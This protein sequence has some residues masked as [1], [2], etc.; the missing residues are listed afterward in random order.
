MTASADLAASTEFS[1]SRRHSTV[2]DGYSERDVLFSSGIMLKKRITSLYVQ[3][4]ELKSYVQLNK[5]G[6]RKVLKKFDKTLERSLAQPYMDASVAPAAPFRDDTLQLIDQNIQAAED[7]YAAVVTDGNADA[8]RRDLRSHLRE[9]VVWE[10]NTVWRDLIGIERRA[11]A[12]SLGQVLLGRRGDS[13]RLRL[14]G[15]AEPSQATKETGAR[16]GRFACP[17]WLASP[18]LLT[19][20]AII[21]MFLV[22]LLVPILQVPEQQNCLALLVFV[23]LLWATEVSLTPPSSQLRPPVLSR[24]CLRSF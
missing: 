22:L 17:A 5:T 14:Q 3:M 15:D 1:R 18:A 6:F 10:R 13:Q 12:A 21:A 19:L 11:E 7:A 24:A 20:A 8:A 16:L 9:H 2:F 23:S 4:C